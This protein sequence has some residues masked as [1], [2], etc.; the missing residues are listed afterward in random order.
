MK[1]P[2]HGGVDDKGSG[3]YRV[4]TSFTMSCV[5]IRSYTASDQA[6]VIALWR[7][8]GLVRPWNDPG[9]D[10]ARKLTVQSD[11]FL[12]AEIDDAVVASAMAGY[13]G[14]RGWINYLAVAASWQKSGVGR[15]IMAEAEKR[16]L[17]LGC[18]K[19]NVQ[20]REDNAAA[21][22]FYQRLGFDIDATRSMGK[23]LIDDD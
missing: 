9:K 3:V 1:L 16:L 19:I 10:I 8:T 2:Y 7:E 18:P 5:I 14:H 6:A 13:D 15:A 23:R 4:E 12:V 17:A 11:L 21:I 22:E 20:I